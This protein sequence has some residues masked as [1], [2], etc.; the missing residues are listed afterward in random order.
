MLG[1]RHPFTR[2]LYEKDGNGKVLV[3]DTEGRWGRFNPDGSWVEG[4]LRDC[5]PQLCNW[6][7][8]PIAGNHR[9]VDA[10]RSDGH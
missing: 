9:L 6:I 1:H 5:D 4:D 2:A 10:S 8:G 3:T 7:A